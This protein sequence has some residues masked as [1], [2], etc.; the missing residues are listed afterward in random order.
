MP[1]VSLK[2]VLRG[3]KMKTLFVSRFA[4]TWASVIALGACSGGVQRDSL[5][6]AETSAFANAY[7]TAVCDS[8][9]PCCAQN[10]FGHDPIWCRNR[11]TA[12][13]VLLSPENPERCL[14][15]VKERYGS[16]GASSDRFA[17]NR[18][19]RSASTPPG[20]TCRTD[21]ECAVTAEF[22]RCVLERVSDEPSYVGKCKAYRSGRV[23]D[24]CVAADSQGVFTECG[25]QVSF[26]SVDASYCDTQSGICTA[27]GSK[28]TQT[29]KN[30]EACVGGVVCERS[31]RCD[32]TLRCVPRAKLGEACLAASDCE[33]ELCDPFA[34]RC[35]AQ[36]LATFSLCGR[37]LTP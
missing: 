20:S 5:A 15:A 21:D 4:W 30:G 34:R 3:S 6:E 17:V 31:S 29:V 12:D 27:Y 18:E 25:P 35:L 28:P 26:L 16:C 22:A 2:R 24:Q 10:A 8:L 37:D 1:N 23:G 33:S 11:A 7:A 36:A 14:R 19:C 13:A 32:K 9:A